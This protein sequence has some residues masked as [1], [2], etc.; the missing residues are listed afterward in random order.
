RS[1]FFGE[2]R[3]CSRI[4]LRYPLQASDKSALSHFAITSQI[5]ARFFA[6]L[7]GRSRRLPLD[8]AGNST[9]ASMALRT[10]R[11]VDI[12][13]REAPATSRGFLTFRIAVKVA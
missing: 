6:I 7:I 1:R 2:M 13:M 11:G 3:K 10:L 9:P 12:T 8:G 4:T 5:L